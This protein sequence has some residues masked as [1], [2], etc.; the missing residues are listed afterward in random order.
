MV[1]LRLNEAKSELEPVQDI[2]FLGASVTLGS[3]KSFPPNIQSS[4]DN[5]TRMPNILENLSNMEVSQFMRSLNWASGLTPLGHL[6]L[7]PLQRHFHSLGLTNQFSPPRPSD[8]LLLATLLRQWQDLSFVTLG[9][10]IR[11]FQ[12]KFMIFTDASTQ[13]W[14]P[15]WGILRLQVYGP[16]WR[17]SSTSM[18]WS[19]RR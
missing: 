18:C 3:E 13:G 6:H 7:R 9:I 8:P 2:Q 10:P 15:T 4:G 17:A 12:A 5:G 14:A 16:V 1:G 19:L 11:P